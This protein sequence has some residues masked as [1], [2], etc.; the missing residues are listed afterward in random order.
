MPEQD[1]FLHTPSH[2]EGISF[3][4]E[5]MLDC[6]MSEEVQLELS[7][8]LLGS[9][10]LANIAGDKKNLVV[11]VCLSRATEFYEDIQ[12]IRNMK[13]YDEKNW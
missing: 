2:V 13:Y 8:N 5:G 9:T 7:R 6:G 11:S 1:T 12:E 10:L 4:L 3:L